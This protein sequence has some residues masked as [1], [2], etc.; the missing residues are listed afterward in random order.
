M[1][2]R[3]VN[4]VFDGPPGNEAGRFV[5]VEN[6]NG[7]SISF[8]EWIE[9][10]QGYWALTFENPIDR[11]N[12]LEAENAELRKALV[13][14]AIPLE[15]LQMAYGQPGDTTFH[16]DMKLSIAEA[17][18]SVRSILAKHGGPR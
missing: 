14:C 9:Y 5:E 18:E 17:I 12:A 15:A 16:D 6:E 8:G 10:Q 13:R 1:E 11:L 3:L 7:H 2:K 4:I